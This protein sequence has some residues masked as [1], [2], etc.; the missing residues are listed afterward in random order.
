MSTRFRLL[1]AASLAALLAGPVYAADPA[2]AAPPP[3]T[4]VSSV[5]VGT[6]KFIDNAAIGDFYEVRAAE[7]A[8]ERSKSADIKSFA[9][10]MKKAHTDTSEKMAPLA[11]AAGHPAP[12]ELDQA[13]LDKLKTLSEATDAEFDKTYVDQQVTAHHAALVMFQGYGESGADAALKAFAA[14]TAPVIEG[15]YKH[16]QML[17]DGLEKAGAPA[18]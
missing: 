1:A 15:H 13:H 4:D 9:E 8:L 10:D 17:Q 2:P 5:N 3:D 16:A 6:T 11:K 18:N 7:L 14:E 12:T